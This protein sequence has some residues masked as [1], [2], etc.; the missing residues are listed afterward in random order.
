MRPCSIPVRS[1]LV[2][3][4]VPVRFS[5]VPLFVPVRS[6]LIWLPVPVRFSLVYLSVPVRSSFIRLLLFSDPSSS[7]LLRIV[8]ASLDLLHVPVCSSINRIPV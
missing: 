7:T 6:S 1:S 5:L 4:A 2:Y 3:L 8:H